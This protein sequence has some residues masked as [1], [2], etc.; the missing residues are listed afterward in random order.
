MAHRAGKNLTNGTSTQSGGAP[1]GQGGV[2]VACGIW[3]LKSS[4][5]PATN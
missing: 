1:A 4:G 3:D 5:L 2:S